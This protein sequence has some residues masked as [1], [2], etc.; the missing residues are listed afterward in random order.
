MIHFIDE[1]KDIIR[2]IDDELLS[3]RMQRQEDLFNGIVRTYSEESKLFE[4]KH[5]LREVLYQIGKND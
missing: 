3:I 2:R 1:L 5:R 4:L